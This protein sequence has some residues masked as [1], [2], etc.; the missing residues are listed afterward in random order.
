MA[1]LGLNNPIWQALFGERCH[2]RMSCI[3]EP[4]MLQAWIYNFAGVVTRCL[5]KYG[6]PR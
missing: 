3:M 6:P 1:N 2:C 4:N 5:V